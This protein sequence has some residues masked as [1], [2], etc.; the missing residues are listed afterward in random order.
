MLV[1]DRQPQ[2]TQTDAEHWRGDCLPR[3]SL[4]H[5]PLRPVAEATDDSSASGSSDA[6]EETEVTLAA[7][8]KACWTR[9]SQAPLIAV[10]PPAFSELQADGSMAGFD[11]DYE[12]GSSH[13]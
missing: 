11:A 5:W 12:C 3:Y 8:A 10:S 4:S 1:A 2:Q 7:R 9:S 6:A 13:S